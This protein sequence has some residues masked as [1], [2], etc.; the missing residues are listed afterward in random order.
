M[1]RNGSVIAGDGTGVE[2][3]REALNVLEVAGR[4]V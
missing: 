1:E 2:I 4:F 3:T